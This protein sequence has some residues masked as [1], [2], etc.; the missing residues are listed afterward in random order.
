M[1]MPENS[2]PVPSVARIGGI[3]SLAIR[4]VY[5]RQVK[6][7]PMAGY[8]SMTPSFADLIF[9]WMLQTPRMPV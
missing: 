1:P 6:D 5:K 9:V 2:S 8:V 3:F 7:R 4:D